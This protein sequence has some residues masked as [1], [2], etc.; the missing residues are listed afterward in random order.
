MAKSNVR[1]LP[2]PTRTVV[3]DSDELAQVVKDAVAEAFIAVGLDVKDPAAMQKDLAYLRTWRE[4]MHKG[5]IKALMTAITFAT[6][7]I[8]AAVMSGLGI[9]ERVM[10]LFGIGIST[11]TT[12]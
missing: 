7:G 6:L 8:M 11:T 12:P 10:H 4:L 1:K 3:V 2:R 9:P 5:G